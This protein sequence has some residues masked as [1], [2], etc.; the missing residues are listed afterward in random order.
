M[1]IVTLR[2]LQGALFSLGAPAGWFLIRAFS[3]ANFNTEIYDHWLLYNYLLFGT[4]IVFM[5][6]GA[7]VGNKEQ[8]ITELAIKDPL[9]KIY[10]LRYFIE[11]IN[12]ELARG[13]RYDLDVGLIYFDLDFF[14]R[15]NDTYGHPAGDKVLVK[16]SDLVRNEIRESDIF[17]RTGGEEFAV[18]LPNSPLDSSIANAE[19]IRIAIENLVIK[20]KDDTIVKVTIS[21]GVANWDGKESTSDFYK[22]AD[23]NLY[24]AKETGRN[25][26]VSS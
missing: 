8:M 21:A 5:L 23:Q 3:G 17:A 4:M 12:E 14:K 19:R 13:R 9:T 18:L 15:V 26:V 10:N 6:F 20:L 11:R 7:F 22:R 24:K 2:I 16:I 25:R 1:N